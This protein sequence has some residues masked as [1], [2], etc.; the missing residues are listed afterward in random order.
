MKKEM[1]EKMDS[2]IVIQTLDCQMRML[3]L[4]HNGVLPA[5]EEMKKATQNSVKELCAALSEWVDL[6]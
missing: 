3:A 5:S 4:I 1:L 6:L 2:R